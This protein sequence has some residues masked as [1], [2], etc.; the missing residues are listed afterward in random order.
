VEKFL[1]EL[2]A[3]FGLQEELTEKWHIKEDDMEAEYEKIMGRNENDPVGVIAAQ[4]FMNYSLWHI[5]DTARRLDVPSSVIADCKHKI[6]VF[7]QKR[8]NLIEKIDETLTNA[9][10]PLLSQKAPEKYNTETLGM[11]IDRMSIIALK[12]FHMREQTLRTD[13]GP[14]HTEICGKKLSQLKEQRERL[15][16]SILDLIDDYFA[17]RKAIKPYFQHKMYNDKSLNPELYGKS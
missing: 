15:R 1:K 11:A 10:T 17:G 8:N 4:H 6:D 14:E 5:E 9:I 13:A 12:I 16:Q 7:N 2:E 3:G